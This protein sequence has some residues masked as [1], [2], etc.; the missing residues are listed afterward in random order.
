MTLVTAAIVTVPLSMLQ[1]SYA[2]SNADLQNAVLSIHNRERDL[3]GVPP[4]TWSNSLAADAQIWA[5]HLTTLGLRC[6]QSACDR[7]PHDQGIQAKGQGENL[8]A[9]GAGFYSTA[10]RVQSWVNEKSNYAGGPY[11]P[12][13]PVVGHYTQMVWQNTNEVGCAEAG[14]EQWTPE[15]GKM[16]FL[17]CRYSPPGNMIGQMP[18]GQ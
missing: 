17:V 13:G 12:S 15:N 1:V 6:T 8:W 10:Q 11:N 9:G 18:F 16:D 4:I 7:P 14:G 2:Q 5:N 3:V